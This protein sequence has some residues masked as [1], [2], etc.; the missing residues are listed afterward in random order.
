MSDFTQPIRFINKI[1]LDKAILFNPNAEVPSFIGP[2]LFL[3]NQ[4]FPYLNP[5]KLL[6]RINSRVG[7]EESLPRYR[8]LLA[9]KN[10]VVG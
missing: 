2:K 5:L 10:A 8:G 7:S 9:H 6:I 4:G 1:R 3:N